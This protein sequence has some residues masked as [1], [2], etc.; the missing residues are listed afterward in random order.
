L[1]LIGEDLHRA[2]ERVLPA[3]EAQSAP[4]SGEGPAP[5]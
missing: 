4:S 3:E 5:Q 2:L 1:V